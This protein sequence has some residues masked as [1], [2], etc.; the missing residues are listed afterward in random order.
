MTAN[1]RRDDETYA[2]AFLR[3]LPTG[4]AWPRECESTLARFILGMSGVWADPVDA[5]AHQ[6]LDIESDP[7]VTDQMLLDWEIAVGLP[8]ECYADLSL[9]IEERHTRLM[10]KLTSIRGQSRDYFLDLAESV[11]HPEAAI[12]EF[13]PFECGES[14]CGWDEHGSPIQ[15]FIWELQLADTP[16]EWFECGD[17]EVGEHAMLEWLGDVL[18]ECLIEK[19]KPSHTRVRFFYGTVST[20]GRGIAAGTSTVVG[21]GVGAVVV[22]F[23]SVPFS[24]SPPVSPAVPAISTS[25]E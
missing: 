20:S 5:R 24:V 25:A 7:R 4:P 23:A 17:S 22:G 11:G 14:E 1:P 15:R 6:L 10:E 13:L 19:R 2:E 18:L 16:V 12:E 21:V 8:E 9:T 3:L